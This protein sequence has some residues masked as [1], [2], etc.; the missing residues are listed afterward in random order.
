MLLD[1]LGGN[2]IAVAEKTNA[3]ATIKQLDDQISDMSKQ[4]MKELLLINSYKLAL[5]RSQLEAMSEVLI[6]SKLT[7]YEE[8]WKKTD[9]NFKSSKL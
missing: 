1:G 8:I 2:M 9:K 4:E 6:K 5:V 3:K 7:T